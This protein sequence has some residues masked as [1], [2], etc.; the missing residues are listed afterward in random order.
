MAKENE[1]KITIIVLAIFAL[2]FLL[3]VYTKFVLYAFFIALGL[4]FLTLVLYV[5]RP[6]VRTFVNTKVFRKKIKTEKLDSDEIKLLNK[7]QRIREYIPEPKKQIQRN[8]SQSDIEELHNEIKLL[9]Q[10]I[11][12]MKLSKQTQEEPTLKNVPTD[13]LM[14][15]ILRRPDSKFT[16]KG[17]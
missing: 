7:Q 12:V 3:V 5:L 10:R 16:T 9:N 17:D 1:T 6:N 11:R 2:I 8:T 13:K 14:E 15:E 4:L